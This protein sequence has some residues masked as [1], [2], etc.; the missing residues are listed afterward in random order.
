M[1]REMFT[2]GGSVWINL[3]NTVILR[4]KRRTDALEEPDKIQ[5]W[6][7]ENELFIRESGS[8]SVS[9]SFH[10]ELVSLR[11]L[12][13]EALKDL[14]RQGRLSDRTNDRLDKEAA[15]LSVDV[16]IDWKEGVPVLVHEGHGFTGR[17]RYAVLNS[18]IDTL[19][20]YPPERIRKCEHE[21]CILH[22]LDSSKGG[23][24]RWCSMDICGNRMKAA[25]FYEKKKERNQMI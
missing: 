4:D 6:L 22:F 18:L 20:K 5:Q 25:E 14:L 10:R 9:N 8:E 15:D 21:A 17:V 24:R 7:T 23:R 13:A 3:A 16:R 2:I 12:C 19:G 11:E 1:E